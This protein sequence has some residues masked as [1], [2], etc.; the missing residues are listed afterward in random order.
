MP[1]DGAI[2]RQRQMPQECDKQFPLRRNSRQGWVRLPQVVGWLGLL[3]AAVMGPVLAAS[4]PAPVPTLAQALHQFVQEQTSALGGQVSLQLLDPAAL[5]ELSPCTVAPEVSL[6]PG[7]RLMGRLS[8]AARCDQPRAGAPWSLMVPVEVRILAH[9]WV[10]RQM[11]PTDHVI[12]LQDVVERSGEVTRPDFI[13]DS[14]DFLG[15]VARQ[16]IAP[17]QLLRQDMLHEVF[18]VHQGQ[19]VPIRVQGKGFDVSSEGQAMANAAEGQSV[20]VRTANG[21]LVT[22]VVKDGRVLIAP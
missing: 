12:T 6:P 2:V 11:I 8:L 10:A 3:W 14:K 4:P 1:M 7:R 22:G 16:G 9:Y 19:T 5:A 17:G 13:S 20:Q 21:R 15:K 18:Q